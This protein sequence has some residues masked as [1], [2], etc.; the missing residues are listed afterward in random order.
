MRFHAA[1]SASALLAVA[2]LAVPCRGDPPVTPARAVTD[3]LHGEAIVDEYRW[4][5]ALEKDSPEVAAWTT[6]QIDRTKSLLGSLPCHSKL[7]SDLGPL[8]SIGSIGLP[9]R[10]GGLAFWT[11]RDG[12]QNQPVLYVGADPSLS[13]LGDAAAPAGPDRTQKRTLLDVNALDAK[14]LTSLDWW[15]PSH[16]GSRVAFGTSKSGSEMSVLCV[17]EVASGRWLADEIS[18]KVSFDGWSP[19][20]NAFVYSKLSDPKDPYSREIR[21]HL[22]GTHTRHDPLI[23]RQTDPSEI[24]GA[25]LSRD[26]RWLFIVKSRGWQASDLFV[27]DFERWQR[28]GMPGMGLAFATIA[29][30]LDGNFFPVA[31]HG[32]TMFMQTSFEAPKGRVVAVDLHSPGC[33]SW[34]TVIPARVDA[35]LESVADADGLLV[36][37]YSKDVTTRIESF[38]LDGRSRGEIALPGLGSAAVAIDETRRD[39]FFSYT[40]F[41]EPRSIYTVNFESGTTALWA[42][43]ELPI[44]PSLVEVQQ[45]FVASKDGTRVPMFVI[46]KKGLALSGQV[47]TIL[48]GYGGFNVSLDPAFD[49]TNWPWYEAGG[50]YAVANLRGGSEYGEEWHKAGMLGRKQNVFDDFYACA[51]WLIDHKVTDSAHLAIEGGSNGGLLTGVAVTQRPDLFCAAISAVPLLDMLRFHDFLIA[52]YWVPEYGSSADKEQF[53]WLRR[54]SPYH[55]VVKGTKYPAVLFT[56]GENDSRV[57]PLHARKMVARMQALSA[58]DDAT[59][60]ILLW[61]DRDAGHGQ[62]KP[63]AKRIE[64]Q[65]DQLAFFMWQ[66]GLCR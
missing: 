7:V 10:E 42:R 13:G 48:Y 14:G 41:N 52:K 56:A 55:H 50:V 30:G 12:A 37:T 58:N 43:P 1:I 65:A 16:D 34:R 33:D 40:S 57:H 21:W 3:T 2:C 49:P 28:L 64:E 66:T 38:T 25:A 46:H 60:P 61:V 29:K 32:S 23:E 17:L 9:K 26:G 39:G 36:A 51:Q 18:G 27:A 54:Y 31:T 35:V 6:L 22:I 44:D 62:G 11:Q 53:A 19:E 47:P 59:D 8:M 45:V 5:E 4:L 20:G 15:Q 24:P 63:L